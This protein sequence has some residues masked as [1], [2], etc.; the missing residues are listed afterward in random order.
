MRFI[1]VIGFS[2]D[3]TCSSLPLTYLQLISLK[4]ATT[5]FGYKNITVFKIFIKKNL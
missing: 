2:S 3:Y 5:K 1:L 4:M